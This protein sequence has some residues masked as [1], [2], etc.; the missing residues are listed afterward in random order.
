[1]NYVLNHTALFCT[2]VVMSTVCMMIGQCVNS[3]TVLDYFSF[4][5]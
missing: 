2:V 3:N 1:M 4:S 5:I